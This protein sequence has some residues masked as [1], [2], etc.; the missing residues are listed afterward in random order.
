MAKSIARKFLALTDAPIQDPHEAMEQ[1][2]AFCEEHGHVVKRAT[3]SITAAFRE[4]SQEVRIKIK[5]YEIEE[6]PNE[7]VLDM[8]R[9]SG[10]AI[11]FNK[12][13]RFFLEVSKGA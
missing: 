4:S 10:D 3:H 1:A 12:I 5:H 8:T 2:A 11:L 9:R 6:F 13:C 7:N